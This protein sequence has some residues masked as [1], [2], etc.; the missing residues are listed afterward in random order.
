MCSFYPSDAGDGYVFLNKERNYGS[1]EA[2]NSRE[3]FLGSYKVFSQGDLLKGKYWLYVLL[4][5]LFFF[6]FSLSSCSPFI[7]T[8]AL[9]Q[10]D[11]TRLMS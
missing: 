1:K 7:T 9:I 5:L 6:P 3:K 4:F 10:L 8:C 2:G 11:L